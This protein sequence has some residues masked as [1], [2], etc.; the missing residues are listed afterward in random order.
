M[1]Q[2]PGHVLLVGTGAY[3]DN[4]RRALQRLGVASSVICVPSSLARLRP[5][6]DH[7]FVVCT[8][9]KEAW[10]DAAAE[11]DRSLPVTGLVCLV[12]SLMVHTARIAER[13]GLPW[14][15]LEVA[16]TVHDKYR[17]RA[18][19]Q[20]AGVRSVPATQVESEDDV[21]AFAERVGWPIVV[22]PVR[23]TGSLGVARLD[24]PDDVAGVLDRGAQHLHVAAAEPVFMAE[25]FMT[26]PQFSVETMSEDG[27]HHVVALTKKYSDPGTLVEVGHSLPVMLP[28]VERVSL[29]AYLTEL[30]DALGV[31]FGPTCTELVWTDDGPTVI[32]SQLRVSGDE[33]QSLV[34]R[35]LGVD[36]I[37]VVV[38]QA[39]GQRVLPELRDAPAAR[40][41]AAI[42]YARFP[43]GGEVLD[44]LGTDEARAVDGVVDVRWTVQPGS[45]LRAFE[46]YG[47]RSAHAVA[48]ASDHEDAARSARTAVDRLGVAISV[49]PQTATYV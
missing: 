5:Q 28:D 1:T 20:D 17:M 15:P 8:P 23:A 9:D 2:T 4:V 7:Q 22:K 18:R 38:R 6:R 36:L 46:H 12:D 44:V 42:W 40:T 25:R 35:A 43:T 14:H 27:A 32:E 41:A 10:I 30:L 47:D 48:V 33:I 39:A 16:A 26:G 37:D 3:Y 19:L 24:G 49:R 31:R 29:E 13:L 21:R 45:T 34:E 11:I